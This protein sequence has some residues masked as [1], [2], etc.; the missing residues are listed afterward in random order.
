MY[1]ADT[2]N[3]LP[4]ELFDI[5]TVDWMFNMA[6]G[7]IGNIG[8]IKEPMSVYRLHSHGAWSGKLP[9]EQLD[10]VLQSIEVYNS[11]LKN[12]YQEQF[13]RLKNQLME[14]KA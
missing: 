12:K 1:R 6:C 2:I 4:S 5:Y 13:L 9:K 8:F 11:F 10:A 14:R 3:K 7:E